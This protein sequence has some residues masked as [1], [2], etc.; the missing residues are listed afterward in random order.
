MFTKA[1][2]KLSKKEWENAPKTTNPVE[3]INRQ[4]IHEKGSGLHTLIENFYLEDRTHTAKVSAIEKNV[5]LSYSS[6]EEARRKKRNDQ[7]KRKRSSLTRS[8]DED[9]NAPPDKRRNVEESRSSNK[10][11]IHNSTRGKGLIGTKIAV[12]FQEER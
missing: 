4:S 6:S 11:S 9:D 10:K 8:G 3:S 1:F 2:T 12:E 5:S 7:R